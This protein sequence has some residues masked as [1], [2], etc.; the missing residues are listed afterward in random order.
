MTWHRPLVFNTQGF[1]LTQSPSVL[2]ALVF[3]K[4]PKRSQQIIRLLCG[5]FGV[6]SKLVHPSSPIFTYHLHCVGIPVF[7]DLVW[8]KLQEMRI[9]G[10]H[11]L[12]Y[13]IYIYVWC[14]WCVYKYICTFLRNR[15]SARRYAPKFGIGKASEFPILRIPLELGVPLFFQQTLI[16]DANPGETQ[17]LQSTNDQRSAGFIP[18]CQ[19]GAEFLRQRRL[20]GRVQRDHNQGMVKK[21]TARLQEWNTSQ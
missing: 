8:R 10:R 15:R 9:F 20:F 16:G 3:S 21:R 13:N 1:D 4:W 5:Y 7:Q 11:N 6:T 14:V 17:R 2:N 12:I 19:E 18:F